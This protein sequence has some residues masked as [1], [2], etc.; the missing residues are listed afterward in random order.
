MSKSKKS[1]HESKSKPESHQ[2]SVSLSQNP[3]HAISTPKHRK[4]ESC[5]SIEEIILEKDSK[6]KAHNAHLRQ[7]AKA[8][9]L[10]ELQ[11]APKLNSSIKKHLKTR[12]QAEMIAL[13]ESIPNTKSKRKERQMRKT[14]RVDSRRPQD[15]IPAPDVGSLKDVLNRLPEKTVKT[16]VNLEKMTLI[17]KT[18]YFEKVKK[19]KSKEAENK[20]LQTEKKA[21][22]FKPDL[23]K[24]TSKSKKTAAKSSKKPTQTSEKNSPKLSRCHSSSKPEE[25]LRIPPPNKHHKTN[26]VLPTSQNVF[27]SSHYSQ[28]SPIIKNYSFKEGANLKELKNRSQEMLTYNAY[29]N[30]K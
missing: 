24:T 20:K 1:S 17:E 27:L 23:A 15:F 25:K 14:Q 11:E 7:V 10:K 4:E 29:T 18:E 12:S 6:A 9:E 2:D 22:T 8:Q 19:D 30:R 5:L 21:C 3:E 16:K 28:F 13:I 26:S